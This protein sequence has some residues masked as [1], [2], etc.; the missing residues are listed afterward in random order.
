MDELRMPRDPSGKRHFVFPR[1]RNQRR[2]KKILA[3]TSTRQCGGS[4]L[5]QPLSQ[6]SLPEHPVV[7]TPHA[8][9][10]TTLHVVPRSPHGP[11]QHPI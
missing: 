2:P 10:T 4:T 5:Q 1:A 11:A 8:E 7:D 3:R 9:A 6:V